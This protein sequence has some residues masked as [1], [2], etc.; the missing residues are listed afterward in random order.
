M[1]TAV[2]LTAS[3]IVMADLTAV[4]AVMSGDVD[5]RIALFFFLPHACV[6]VPHHHLKCAPLLLF[7]KK[8]TIVYC[9]TLSQPHMH[10]AVLMNTLADVSAIIYY[11]YTNRIPLLPVVYNSLMLEFMVVKVKDLSHFPIPSMDDA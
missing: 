1:P 10:P 6:S 3:S 7:Y 8:I 2:V 11:H 9:T 4:M 5:V